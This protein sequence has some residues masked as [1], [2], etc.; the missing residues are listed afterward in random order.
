MGYFSKLY[1]SKTHEIRVYQFP[2]WNSGRVGRLPVGSLHNS[3][4]SL[5]FPMKNTFKKQLIFLNIVGANFQTYFA[6]FFTRIDVKT[7][8]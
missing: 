3:Q 5:S 1:Q 2:V 8:F 6:N 4:L 7:L